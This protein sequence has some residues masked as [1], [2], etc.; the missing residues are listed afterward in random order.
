MKNVKFISL[1]T[2]YMVLMLLLMGPSSNLFAQK[3]RSI[4]FSKSS[5]NINVIKAKDG[6]EYQQINITDL[7]QNE[8]PGSPGLPSKYLRLLISPDEDVEDIIVSVKK[9]EVINLA[10]KLI[11]YQNTNPWHDEFIEPNKS[12]YESDKQYPQDIISI[13]SD[14]YFASAYHIIML[15][16]NPV[17]YFPAENKIE[18][19]SELEFT[20]KM[21]TADKKPLVAAKI[22]DDVNNL[23]HLVDNPE[24]IPFYAKTVLSK[25]SFVNKVTT[26]PIYE[27]VIIT[28]SSLVSYFQRFVDWKKRKG[29]DIGIVTV[30]DIITNYLNGDLVSGIADSAGSIRQY[31]QDCKSTTEWVLLGGDRYT[32]PVRYGT[33]DHNLYTL[34]YNPLVPNDA[35]I[36]TDLYYAELDE[37]WDA[38]ADV[39]IGEPWNIYSGGDI[40]SY[41]PELYVGRLL[42]SDNYPQGIIIG[43]IKL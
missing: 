35:K 5:L 7:A 12:I 36:P 40:H 42:C 33:G 39:F 15:E 30:G 26:V 21:K 24:E 10:K 23:K 8:K 19:I 28:K 9:S 4:S 38:D 16:I 6:N 31:L 25:N 11:P 20:L 3:T 32:V 29:I 37:D 2:I 13:V 22:G 43:Q 1:I 34:P 41:Y 17:L 14:G 27:Y 18:F